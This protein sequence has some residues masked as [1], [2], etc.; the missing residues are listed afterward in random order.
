MRCEKGGVVHAERRKNALAQNLAERRAGDDLD[1]AAEH[2]GR[3]AVFPDFARLKAQ[4]QRGERLDV[5][6]PWSVPGSS[7]PRRRPLL[8]C[9]SPVKP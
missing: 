9:K 3:V 5:L 7:V 8:D 2:V 1:D 4:R 6:A